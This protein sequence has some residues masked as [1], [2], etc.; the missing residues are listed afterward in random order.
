MFAEKNSFKRLTCNDIEQRT[1]MNFQFHVLILIAK[2]NSKPWRTWGATLSHIQ[3]IVL[4]NAPTV[5][6]L[7]KSK[8]FFAFTRHCTRIKSHFHVTAAVSEAFDFL[9]RILTFVSFTGKEF[10]IKAYLKSHLTRHISEK[11]FACTMCKSAFKRRYDLN[12]HI[13]K[14][15]F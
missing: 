6:R 9:P 8:G 2:R 1:V 10:S 4:T 15:H 7:S 3:L 11:Q 5:K 13:K 12:F 14:I